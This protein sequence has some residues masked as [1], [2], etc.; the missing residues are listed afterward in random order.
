MS[1]D[2]GGDLDATSG[3]ATKDRRQELGRQVFYSLQAIIRNARLHDEN[4]DAF[5][6]V[7]QQLRD[8]LRELIAT[9]GAFS[10]KVAAD[11][12]YVNRQIVRIEAAAA[13]LA[14]FVRSELGALGIHGIS[15]LETPKPADLRALV[16]VF[17]AAATRRLGRRGDP[18]RPLSVLSLLIEGDGEAEPKVLD[19]QRRM[20][21]AYSHAVLFVGRYVEL[22]R[23]GSQAM[24]IWAASRVVQD[25]VDLQRNAP[26]RFLQLARTKGGGEAYLG[27]HA[28]NVAVLAISFGARLG[29]EKKRCHDLG[30]SALFHD[31]GMVALPEALLYKETELDERDRSAVQASPL[32]TARAILRD[33]E[34]HPAALE[35]AR[36]AYECHLD[37]TCQPVSAV[38]RIL[39]ICES[40]DALTTARPWRV[41]LSRR[42]ALQ[43][44]QAEMTGRLDPALLQLFPLATEALE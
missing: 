39:A 42:D 32:L 26:L 15:A 5:A 20:V 1:Q 40:Y 38:G 35:R 23:G 30:M 2:L 16:H 21:D 34:V 25:L 28:A 17:T 19:D 24:P 37:L 22:L 12:L 44:M 11:G 31:V 33:R 13:P 4:N 29:F 6:P 10:L 7:L 14:A 43:R 36:A 8:A 18:A 9:D 3:Q 27:Y 41:A